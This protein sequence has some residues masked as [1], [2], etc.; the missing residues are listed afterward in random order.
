M[1]C[2]SCDSENDPGR[3]FCVECGARLS[4]TCPSCGTPYEPGMK[5]CGE[6]G[7]ASLPER[8]QRRRGH[9]RRSGDRRPPPP[10][11]DWFRSCSRTWWGSLALSETRDAED[12]RDLLTRYFDTCRELVTRYGGEIEKFIGDAVMAVWGAPTT[13]EDDAERAVRAALDLT[14]AVRRWASEIGLTGSARARG[15]L[16]GEAAVTLGAERAGDGGR[17]P[18]EHRVPDPVGC[19]SRGG[20]GRGGDQARHRGG[21]RLRGRRRPRC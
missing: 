5:F 15:V 2:P 21:D 18:G 8:M 17:R 7:A 20:P 19:A 12:V 6:C 9:Q 1:R 16:T 10:S 4:A 3:K 13:N 11:G 14:A